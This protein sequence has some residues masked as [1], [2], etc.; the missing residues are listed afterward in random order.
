METK[1]DI[2]ITPRDRMM[3]AWQISM[4]LVLQ[5]RRF[6]QECED[7]TR[8]QSLLKE[9]A[10]DECVHASELLEELHRLSD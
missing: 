10:E 1:H 5:Y 2:P 3:Y 6:A 4:E 7:D 9:L 8:V